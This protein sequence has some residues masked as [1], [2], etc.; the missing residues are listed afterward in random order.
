MTHEEIQVLL[1]SMLIPSK[2]VKFVKPEDAGLKAKDIDTLYDIVDRCESVAEEPYYDVELMKIVK[3]ADKYGFYN[4]ARTPR[5][6]KKTNKQ[7]VSKSG[8]IYKGHMSIMLLTY[9]FY[10]TII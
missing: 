10:R 7:M 6:D 5:I 9:A 2:G 1:D 8:K 3:I 4:I